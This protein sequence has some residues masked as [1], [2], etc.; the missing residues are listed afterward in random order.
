MDCE[1]LVRLLRNSEGYL[2]LLPEVIDYNHG[3]LLDRDSMQVT[4]C[5]A[6]RPSCGCQAGGRAGCGQ[7]RGSA[8]CM[9][10]TRTPTPP[11]ASPRAPQLPDCLRGPAPCGAAA[12]EDLL[13]LFLTQTDSF[14]LPDGC[15]IDLDWLCGCDDMCDYINAGTLTKRHML[16]LLRHGPTTASSENAAAALVIIFNDRVQDSR[17]RR[18]TELIED[19]D[20]AACIRWPYLSPWYAPVLKHLV[21]RSMTGEQMASPPLGM[22][23]G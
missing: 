22:G 19:D 3:C 10:R 9:Q 13:K 16:W 18:H 2:D 11:P 8:A 17:L 21:E 6:G 5:T 1:E 7:L 14:C 20:I 4:P 23:P 15:R 12:Q